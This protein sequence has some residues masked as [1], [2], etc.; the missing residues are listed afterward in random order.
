MPSAFR[1]PFAALAVPPRI[2]VTIASGV[3]ASSLADQR[4][5]TSGAGGTR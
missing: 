1:R 4:G 3:R 5:G 2:A